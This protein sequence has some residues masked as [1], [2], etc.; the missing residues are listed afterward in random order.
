MAG[1]PDQFRVSPSL[2]NLPTISSP[3]IENRGPQQLV[4]MGNAVQNAGRAAS[5]LYEAELVE[6]NKTRVTKALTD[7]TEYRNQLTHDPDYGWSTLSGQNALERPDGK[8]LEEEYGGDFENRVGV[9]SQGLGNDAQ[10]RMF[11]EAAASMGVDLRSRLQ[12]HTA[13]QSR[14]F[15]LETQGGLVDT[16]SRQLAMAASEEE[17]AEALALIRNGADAIF[18]L[19]GTP[20]EARAEVLR[21]LTTPGH[22][23]QLSRMLESEDLSGA[24]AYLEQYRDD[25]TVDA[26]T[27]VTAVLAEQ[28]SITVASNVGTETYDAVFGVGSASAPPAKGDLV[29]VTNGGSI[30]RN[31]F[32]NKARITSTHRPANHPL[33][34]KNPNSWHT[35]SNAAVDM[36][37]IAGM[38]FEQA[39][40]QIEGQG[41]HLIEAINE[42]GK[43]RTAHATGDHWHFVIGSK[44]GQAPTPAQTG[45]LEQAFRAID[46]R[47]DLTEKQKSMAKDKVRELRSARDYDRQQNE[48]QVLSRAYAEVDRTGTL[49]N[50]TRAALVGAGM[51][52]SIPS[53]RS[54]ENATRARAQAGGTV[55]TDVSAEAYGRVT[56]AI[57]RGEVQTIDQLMVFKPFLSDSMF[58]QLSDDIAS[59]PQSA[60]EKA[61]ATL[62]L[63]DEEIEG[64]GLFTDEDG[65]RTKEKEKE[66]NRFVTAVT[67]TIDGRE[68][69][70]KTV[71][72][73][74]RRQIV[75]GMLAQSSVD[76]EMR[77]NY[78]VEAMYSSVPP[79]ARLAITRSL[80][81]RNESPTQNKIVTVW[82]R[83]SDEAKRGYSR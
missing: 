38:T 45:S 78:D 19:K 74:E 28:Q 79:R 51:G 44:D 36:A 25:L 29:P 35:K 54:F 82:N 80:E 43:G 68:L 26:E 56:V 8:T 3:A 41:Y 70:G 40:A 16:G 31:I 4:E 65:K 13:E 61:A 10:R 49:S 76:G 71:T 53:L 21:E 1:D 63:L 7:L 52:S 32:G 47:E 60:R 59:Q 39:K 64:S 17:R 42:V 14:V 50:S 24:S 66:Y 57:A 75:L 69:N 2:S 12:S 73:E 67:R 58:K 37:P 81:R 22:M 77:R 18:S 20:Q 46:D 83:L 72:N 62:K 15:Q 6:Q 33:S 9:L 48:E 30:A 5:S 23:A 27:K 55:A 34:R 11:E